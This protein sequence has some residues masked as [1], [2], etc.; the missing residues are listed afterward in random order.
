MGVLHS[1]VFYIMS[2]WA[3]WG[4]VYGEVGFGFGIHIGDI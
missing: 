4:F 1:S 3:I 2:I